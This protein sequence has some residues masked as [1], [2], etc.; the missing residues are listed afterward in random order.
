MKKILSILIVL[1]IGFSF[2]PL[3]ANSKDPEEGKE[4]SE[5]T[6]ARYYVDEILEEN[7][8]PYGIKHQTVWGY[9]STP[10]LAG[11]NFDVDGYQ[12]ATGVTVKDQFYSQNINV[13]TIPSSKNIKVTTW[14]NI[15]NTGWTLTTVKN[16]IKDFEKNNPGWKV[17]AAINGDTFDISANLYNLPYQT[18]GPAVTNGNFYKTTDRRI[19]GSCG[20]AIGFKNDGSTNPLFTGKYEVDD[21][22]TIEIMDENNNILKSFKASSWNTLPESGSSIYYGTYNEDQ[23]YVSKT[24]DDITDEKVF[25]VEK[26]ALALPNSDSDFYGRGV[27]SSKEAKTLEIG[28]FAI[29]TKDEEVQ[30]ALGIGSSIRVQRYTVGDFAG[31]NDI[32]AFFHPLMEDG[33]YIQGYNEDARAPRTVFGV[34]ATGDIVMMV[35]D[36]RQ[37]LTTVDESKGYVGMFGCDAPESAA[38]MKYYGCVDA[39]NLDGGG[40]STMVIRDGNDFRTLNWPSDGS[41]RRDGNCLVVAVKEPELNISP[42]LEQNKMNL[43]INVVNNNGHDLSKLFIDVTEE[44]KEI[45]GNETITSY[46]KVYEN[47]EVLEN[48]VLIDKLNSATNYIINFSYQNS[49]GD[50]FEFMTTEKYSTLKKEPIFKGVVITEDDANYYIK[51]L[52]DDPDKSVTNPLVNIN[53]VSNIFNANNEVVY[54]KKSIGEEISSFYIILSVD[55]SDTT[56]YRKTI[57]DPDFISLYFS[58]DIKIKT[59]NM[60]NKILK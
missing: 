19:H 32:S 14:S 58:N 56:S 31:I 35:V 2:V 22:F 48:K 26:V 9:T 17:I 29:V 36:G 42:I 41:E 46:K 12:G 37:G 39:Y 38:I 33:E 40:S 59:N 1:I 51:L 45:I 54:S 18:G 21:E 3:S 28:E 25:V 49:S 13:L 60:L 55:L 8:L 27:V 53:S 34:T 11:V 52:L 10:L 16:S 24:M 6:G 30:N 50:F 7:D 47:L 23:N 15:S 5:I 44:I 57:Y 20:A 4:V 43:N